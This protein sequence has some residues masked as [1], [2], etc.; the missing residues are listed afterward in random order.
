[1]KCE[2]RILSGAREGYRE[3]LDK[4]Y[5]GLGRHPMSDVR[6][7]AE[8]DIDASTRHAAI[9][10]EGD[11]YILRDLGSTNGTFVGGERVTGDVVLSDGDVIRCGVHGPELAFRIV[12]DQ[13]EV[14]ME[15]VK[16]PRATATPAAPAAPAA[17]KTPTP[18]GAAAATP[19]PPPHSPGKVRDTA[20]SAP[21]PATA[22]KTSILRAEMAVQR[23][24]F[25]AVTAFLL[26]VLLGSAGVLI[27]SN[28]QAQIRI[29]Q[30]QARADSL[31]RYVGQMQAAKSAADS[32]V[33]ALRAALLAESDPGRRQAIQ[34]QM[35]GAVTRL[36]NIERS[37]ATA[38]EV[39][40]NAIRRNNAHAVAV[41][42]VEF[43]D[44]STQF[45]TGTG[46]GVTPDG[47]LLTNRHVVAGASGNQR[48]RRMAVQFHNRSEVWR[49][50][51]ERVA[52]DADIAVVQIT[53]P[54]TYPVVSGFNQGATLESGSPIALLGFPGY[55]GGNAVPNA[56]LVTGTVMEIVG[57]SLLRLDAFSG[58]GASGSPIL[59]RDGRVIGI[60]FG[61]ERGSGGRTVLGLPIRRAM[62]L[63]GR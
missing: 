42:T 22:S 40:Y 8:K 13:E 6:F 25:R 55:G 28:R 60:E 27:W 9:I 15:A 11:R 47:K 16:T 45:Y 18:A 44:D 30:E 51:V 57:D 63:L 38:E 4:P 50:R 32:T 20:A 35:S 33:R 53:D 24:R 29:Q 39:D 46:F 59:D 41:L 19:V 56:T 2:I 12:R 3:L 43:E 23:Q 1:V 21:K 37:I 10:L 58:V 49:G 7:D 48:V 36:T 31:A 61:G 62:A 17:P 26:I 34:V 5:I 54:G 14:V 52:P